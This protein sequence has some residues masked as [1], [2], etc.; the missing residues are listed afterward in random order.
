M[1]KALTGASSCGLESYNDVLGRW[2][3]GQSANA[4]HRRAYRRIADFVAL[5]FPDARLILDYACGAGDLLYQLRRRTQAR[6]IGLDGSEYLLNLARERLGLT[7]KLVPASL[8]DFELR[9]RAEVVVCAVPNMLP[10]SHRRLRQL[11][12][13]HLDLSDRAAALGICRSQPRIHRPALLLDRLIAR[14]LRWLLRRGG[15]C[16]R[17]EYAGIPRERIGADDLLRSEYEEGT[18]SAEADSRPWFRVVAST[19]LRSRVIADVYDQTHDQDDL[20]GGYQ[21]TV[22]RA[23]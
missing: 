23:L 20:Q 13:D 14:N 10:T 21:I 17:V 4:A 2:W 22:L 11:I 16:V 19:Y 15:H 7:V 3:H 1:R 12:R 5:S 8:P 6:L 9:L 18:W